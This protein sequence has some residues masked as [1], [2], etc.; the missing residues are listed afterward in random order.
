MIRHQ[1]LLAKGSENVIQQTCGIEEMV[2]DSLG[3]K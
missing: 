2:R 3:S 1:V